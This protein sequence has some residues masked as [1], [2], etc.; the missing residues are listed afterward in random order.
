MWIFVA[1]FSFSVQHSQRAGRIHTYGKWLMRPPRGNHPNGPDNKTS[2]P[3]GTS[4]RGRV[5]V[6]ELFKSAVIKS[7]NKLE[8][9]AL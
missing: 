5:I 7:L 6:A 8:L 1:G 9:K 3:A 2:S 4:D